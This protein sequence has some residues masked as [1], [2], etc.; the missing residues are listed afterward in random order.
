MPLDVHLKSL[1]LIGVWKHMNTNLISGSRKLRS[2]LLHSCNG[3]LHCFLL[4]ICLFSKSLLQFHPQ[5]H[6][7][8][9][10][11]MPTM[12]QNKL[13][14]N[15]GNHD[16]GNCSLSRVNNDYITSRN[17]FDLFTTH[18]NTLF[19]HLENVGRHFQ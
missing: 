17:T 2:T 14:H 7:L 6:N 18:L 16:T 3:C 12:Q 19:P 9:P 1:I 11:S 10:T 15:Q 5:N 4:L 8:S 13:T